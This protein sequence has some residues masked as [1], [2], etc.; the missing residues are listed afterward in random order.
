MNAKSGKEDRDVPVAP[1]VV[2]PRH[3][4]DEVI[5]QSNSGLGIKYA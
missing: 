2:I 4:F 1:F 3:N 5:V